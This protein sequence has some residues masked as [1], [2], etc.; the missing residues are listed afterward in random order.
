MKPKT[1]ALIVLSFAMTFTTSVQAATRQQ[2]MDGYT[3]CW[4]AIVRQLPDVMGEDQKLKA[5]KAIVKKADW[6]CASSR[7]L[8]VSMNGQRPVTE[9]RRS[10][11]TQFYNANF[12]QDQE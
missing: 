8:A 11:E 2:A 3:N 7:A 1:K 10:M 4:S 6:K 12:S 5:A 9:M